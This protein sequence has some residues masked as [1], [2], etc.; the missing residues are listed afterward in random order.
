MRDKPWYPVA[1]M[2][3]VTAAFSGILIGVSA[4]TRERVERNEQIFRERAILVAVGEASDDTSAEQ[5]H[6]RYTQRIRPIKIDPAGSDD[7]ENIREYQLVAATTDEPAAMAVP[8]YGQGFWDEI[9]GV[10]GLRS[11]RRTII[12]IVFYEQKET[13]GLG[14]EIAKPGF[15]DQFGDNKVLAPGDTPIDIRPSGAALDRSSVHAVTGATQTCTRL[16][17]F[18]NAQLVKWRRATTEGGAQ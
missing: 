15:R 5:V 7:L 17:R 1:Y 4:A 11:D 16:E 10:I 14:A 8:I 6:Q 12:A 3:V 2:F 18:L 13:P 9:R